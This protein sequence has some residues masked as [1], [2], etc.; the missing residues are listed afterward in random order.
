MHEKFRKIIPGCFR[1]DQVFN[2][3]I[4]KEI[5]NLTVT[6]PSIHRSIT[7]LI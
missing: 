1:F 7:A 5:R 6:N 4:R 3:I 2:D